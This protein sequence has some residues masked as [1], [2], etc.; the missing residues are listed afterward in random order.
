MRFDVVTLFPEMV[1]SPASGSIMGRALEAGKVELFLHDPR[2]WSEDKNRTVDDAPFGGGDGMVMKTAPLAGAI[3]SAKKE[4]PDSP[5]VLL[6][7]Q[8]ERFR[9]ETAE[10]FARLS[11]LVL[12]CG[13]YAGIDER[14]RELLIDREL[15]IGDYVLSGGEPAAVV[16]MD[17]V[18][19][20]VP[21]VLGNE[22]SPEADSFPDRLEYPQYTRPAEFEGLEV[23][24][25]LLSGHH[26]KVARWR[27]KEGLKRTL[28]R[29]PDLF[30]LYPPDE[31]ERELLD[32]IKA[33]LERS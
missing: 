2:D 7:P 9:Q 5:V 23:P 25:V 13:R 22:I 18:S 33:E 27:K 15:S 30:E 3:R 31:E 1:A 26:E 10:E 28:L 8:G 6:T 32:E 19:R 16:V 11:G 21:G 29:R 12:V 20:L 14:V 17:A 4:A 24:E